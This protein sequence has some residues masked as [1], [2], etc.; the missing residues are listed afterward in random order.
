MDV[1]DLSRSREL[2]ERARRVI[3][4]GVYGHQNP[5]YLVAG[6]YPVFLTEAEGCRVRD[7]DGNTYIDFLCAYGP[8]VVG[9]RNPVVERA[10]ERQ[11]RRCDSGNL[12]AP[13]IIELAER[14]VALT[15]GADW[16]VF[17]KNGS[18]VTTW[19]LAVARQHTGRELIAMAAGA[20][21]GVHGWCNHLGKGFTDT[22]RAGVVQFAWNDLQGLADLFHAHGDSLAAV[23]ITPFRHEA[24]ADS[25]MPA[26]GFLEAVRALSAHH[27]TVMIVDDIRAGFRL[28]IGGSTQLF[29]ITP[30]LLLYSKALA[31]GY[32]LSAMLGTDQLRLACEAVFVTGTFFTQAVPIAAALATLEVLQSE[33]GIALMREAGS[34]FCMGLSSLSKEAGIPVTISG[35]PAIPFMTFDED[36]GTF[37]RSRVFATACI[38]RGVFLH[39]VHNWF[40]STMHSNTDIDQ[41]LDAAAAGFAAVREAFNN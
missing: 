31:N 10:V 19:S 24:G 37:E 12:P 25:V 18:D 26:K 29:G 33:N 2:L 3:P 39:P 30:D 15:P 1:P 35:P 21:H 28:H 8:M 36:M 40:V 20:Y 11:R 34:G 9:Y 7:P 32:P 27:G 6:D 5:A 4:G 38:R 16:S 41:A 23:I 17:A 13:N 14:L 22:D